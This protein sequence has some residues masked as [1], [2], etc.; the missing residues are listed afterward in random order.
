MV[1]PMSPIMAGRSVTTTDASSDAT[2]RP[3]AASPSR[4]RLFKLWRRRGDGDR[5]VE[6][7]D[8]DLYDRLFAAV[9]EGAI[10]HG[11]VDEVVGGADPHLRRHRPAR[12]QRREKCVP[13]LRGVA[14]RD[15]VRIL[16]VELV[17][18]DIL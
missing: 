15:L 3:V 13:L 8:V 9:A 14:R 2:N 18:R 7:R 6:A 1:R 10:E 4:T 11:F 5:G 16:A 12:V 17:G